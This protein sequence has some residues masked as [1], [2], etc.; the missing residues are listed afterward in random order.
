MRAVAFCFLMAMLAEQNGAAYTIEWM[1]DYCC[2]TEK[3]AAESI[4]IGRRVTARA[5]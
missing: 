2:M 4:A 1:R 3:E 5:P